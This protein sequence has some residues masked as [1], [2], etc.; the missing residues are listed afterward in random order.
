MHGIS[1]DG[2]GAATQPL[3]PMEMAARNG[4]PS[5]V[6]GQDLRH[7]KL[8]RKAPRR[9][10]PRHVDGVLFPGIAP[11]FRIR[12]GDT[13]LTVGSCFAREIERNLTGFNLPVRELAFRP[14]EVDGDPASIINEYNSGCIAQRLGWAS[15]RTDTAG[16][17]E[18][19]WGSPDDSYDLILS[20]GSRAPVAELMNRRRRIDAVY[21]GIHDSALLIVTLGLSEVWVD[22]EQ[23]IF[24]NRIP[25][26]IHVRTNPQ[27]Y[28]L[29]MLTPEQNFDLLAPVFQRLI[30]D[31]LQRIVVTVSPV[32]M[33]STFAPQD[34]VVANCMS[35]SSLRVAA[36]RLASTFPGQVDYFPSYEIVTSAGTSAYEDDLIHVRPEMV[37]RIM[38]HFKQAYI[39]T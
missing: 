39:S 32:P 9:D 6:V 12:P 11:S 18:T 14:D 1:A 15:E 20:K 27:R 13:V 16:M 26:W 25:E 35:K 19:V 34:A 28:R 8:D 24:L 4:V 17:H 29:L 37:A 36:G 21:S 38:S 3:S 10:D 2:A 33:G 30:D 22:L 23:G 31:G 5:D 7:T